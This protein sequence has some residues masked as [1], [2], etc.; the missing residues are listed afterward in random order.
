MCN[1]ANILFLILIAMHTFS[2]FFTNLQALKLIY[3]TTP[4]TIQ[5]RLSINYLTLINLFF[6]VC[7][8]CINFFLKQLF[9][10]T[11]LFIFLRVFTLFNCSFSLKRFVSL[12]SCNSLQKFMLLPHWK[13][14]YWLS[15]L[16]AYQLS[17]SLVAASWLPMLLPLLLSLLVTPPVLLML[18]L[19]LPLLLLSLHGRLL[20]AV[21]GYSIL[22]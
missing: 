3:S 11:Y 14:R 21:P 19:L 9:L 17:P 4:F 22:L 12:A 1:S 13:H 18:L 2:Q 16:N 5:Q 10:F 20:I 6:S 7:T 15:A 8:H